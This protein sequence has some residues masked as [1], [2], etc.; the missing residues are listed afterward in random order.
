MN[1]YRGS[2]S[3]FMKGKD[4]W[5]RLTRN[6]PNFPFGALIG[7]NWYQK[8]TFCIMFQMVNQG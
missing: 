3:Y 8:K 1:G 6:A 2:C 4:D 5:I 7:R